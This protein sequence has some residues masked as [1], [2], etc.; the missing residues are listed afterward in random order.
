M[1]EYF[2]CMYEYVPPGVCSGQK[3]VSHPL[4]QELIMAV[5]W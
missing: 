2:A 3:M 4:V 5:N 1:F